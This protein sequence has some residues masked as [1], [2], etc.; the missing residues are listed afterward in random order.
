MSGAD[1]PGNGAV[2]NAD[3]ASIVSGKPFSMEALF[4]PEPR[5][6]SHPRTGA[7]ASEPLVISERARRLATF[8]SDRFIIFR[9]WLTRIPLSTFGL[10]TI[11]PVR[12]GGLLS[13]L[14]KFATGIIPIRINMPAT[15]FSRSSA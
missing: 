9:R 7:A 2:H 6:S 11:Q 10:T 4:W 13:R 8:K 15:L 12:L 3:F 5:Q 14:R 1:C